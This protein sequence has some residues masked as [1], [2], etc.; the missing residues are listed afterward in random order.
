M[1]PRP[2]LRSTPSPQ[3]Q[4]G[5]RS[6]KRTGGTTM[7]PEAESRG[8]A[9]C[10]TAHRLEPM[11]GNQGFAQSE[12]ARRSPSVGRRL[13]IGRGPHSRFATRAPDRPPSY[14]SPP[15]W[16]RVAS[17]HWPARMLRRFSPNRSPDPTSTARCATG[18]HATMPPHP[19]PR[20][21]ASP[22][23]Q[24]SQD[25][26][27]RGRLHHDAPR[28]R[29]ARRNVWGLHAPLRRDDWASWV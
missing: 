26:P 14:S 9:T 24:A 21:P 17:R 28:S 20:S 5:Q 23:F 6:R 13:A 22:R 18:S 8:R 7:R 29:L 27:E 10:A 25:S 15:R 12:G 3:F 4:A 19:L 2:L 1:P 11:T 16:A